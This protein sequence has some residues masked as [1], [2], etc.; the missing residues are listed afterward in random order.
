MPSA[1]RKND[2]GSGHGCFPPSN[3]IEGSSNVSINGRPA[4]RVGD[5]LVSHGCD[6]CSPH[7]RKVAAGSASVSINGK[8]A[9]RVGDAVNCGG[10]MASGSGNVNIGDLSWGGQA[11]L[12]VTPTLRMQLSPIPGQG[13]P[14]YSNEPYKLYKG[15]ALAQQGETDDEG[16]IEYSYEPP[17]TE[18][19]VIE[20]AFGKY[21]YIPEPVAPVDTSPGAQSRLDALGFYATDGAGG[22]ITQQDTDARQYFQGNTGLFNNSDDELYI[23]VI[24]PLIP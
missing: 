1:S 14:A 10:A 22:Q 11:S 7:S 3:A 18:P 2:T 13:E 9:A 5:A 15:G 6:K 19:L 20:T 12:P 4:L 8:P 24:K 16:R 21:E 23:K 17:W